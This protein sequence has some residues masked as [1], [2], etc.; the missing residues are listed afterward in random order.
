L[1]IQAADETGASG[2]MFWDPSNV[3]SVGGFLP[4]P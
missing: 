2:W 4:E 3:Y 1:Q